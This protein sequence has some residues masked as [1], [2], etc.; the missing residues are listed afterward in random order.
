MNQQKVERKRMANKQMTRRTLQS[1]TTRKKICDVSIELIREHGFDGVTIENISKRAGVSVGAFYHHFPSKSDVLHEIFAQIDE[2]FEKEVS[3]RLYGTSCEKL[4][5]YFGYYAGFIN[6]Q[7]IDFIKQ[8][9][10][11]NNKPF[12]EKDRYLLICLK[13]LIIE[14]QQT[15]EVTG[16]QDAEEIRDFLF[17]LVRGV[18]F[19]WCLH[20]GSYDLKSTIQ[21]HVNQVLPLFF[22]KNHE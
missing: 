3:N 7:G 8:L 20:D 21:N 22:D 9:F 14:G 10:V 5:E 2:Y 19:D 18:V 13:N 11:T 15:Q 16:S 17:I 6:D 12:I 1:I 4:N